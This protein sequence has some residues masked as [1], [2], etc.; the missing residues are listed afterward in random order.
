MDTKFEVPSLIQNFLYFRAQYNNYY[1]PTS[2]PC[3]GQP[4]GHS[5]FLKIIVQI[6]SY[7]GQNADQMPHTRVHSGVQ[8]PPPQGHFRGT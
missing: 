7:P 5:T 3:P 8:M 1:V 4:P 2:P 6:S